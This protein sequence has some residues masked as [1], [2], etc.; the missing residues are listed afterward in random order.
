MSCLLGI[1]V[2]VFLDVVGYTIVNRTAVVTHI[3]LV[4]QFIA[5]KARILESV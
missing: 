2:V 4:A 3:C 5:N 1:A